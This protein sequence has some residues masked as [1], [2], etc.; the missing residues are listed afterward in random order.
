MYDQF[1]WE[2]RTKTNQGGS[3]GKSALR[4]TILW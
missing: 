4:G 1:E 3:W 2:K